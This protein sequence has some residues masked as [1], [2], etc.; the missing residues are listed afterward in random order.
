MT[1][2]DTSHDPWLCEIVL[3][4]AA[5]ELTSRP[6]QATLTVGLW[7]FWLVEALRRLCNRRPRLAPAWLLFVQA[8]SCARPI[9]EPLLQGFPFSPLQR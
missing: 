1:I 4:A 6:W 7:C 9:L 2:R 3:R 5:F 8:E